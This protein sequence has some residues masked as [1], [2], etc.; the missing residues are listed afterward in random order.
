M[1]STPH[2]VILTR[3]SAVIPAFISAIILA[4]IRRHSDFISAVILTRRV[5]ISVVAVAVVVRWQ[6][7]SPSPTPTQ[8]TRKPR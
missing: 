3:I 4:F 5:R 7:I 1:P 2:G 8:F 6:T